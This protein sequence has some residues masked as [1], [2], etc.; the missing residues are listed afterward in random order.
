MSE[1]AVAA[2]AES[3]EEQCLVLADVPLPG[4]W[5]AH[6]S[7][8]SVPP[9]VFFPARGDSLKEVKGVCARCIVRQE[10]TDYAIPHV[11]LKGIW[12]GLSEAERRRLRAGRGAEDGAAAPPCTQSPRG[13]LYRTL[14]ELST[15]P[16]HWCR[17]VRYASPESAGAM[18]SLLRSGQRPSPPGE[19]EF[20]V[21]GPNDEGGSDLYACLA[22][23]SA[24]TLGQVS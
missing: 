13:S 14:V 8:R 5:A 18:A 17:V 1:V 3:L 10:C 20:D 23:A 12:G 7:C 6:G 24:Q 4:P 2:W 21:D 22:K 16:G 11:D 15:Y 19:W 9:W